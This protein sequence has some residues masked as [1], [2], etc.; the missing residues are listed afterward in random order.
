MFRVIQSYKAPDRYLIYGPSGSGK[1]FYAFMRTRPFQGKRY[2]IDMDGGAEYLC[3]AGD[4]YYSPSNHIE[5][6]KAVRMAISEKPPCII[7]DGITT[8]WASMVGNGIDVAVRRAEQKK[9]DS[10]VSAI[11]IDPGMW[12]AYKTRMEGLLTELRVSGRN[13]YLIQRAKEIRPEGGKKEDVFWSPEGPDIPSYAMDTVIF[14]K[15]PGNTLVEKV[16]KNPLPESE[17]TDKKE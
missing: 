17:G 5:F 8:Y 2:V 12:S 16:R 15:A 6:E 7:I 9:Q 13:I 14:C 1:S 11:R 3:S 4:K 10:S